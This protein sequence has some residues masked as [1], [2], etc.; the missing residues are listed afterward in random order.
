MARL[1]LRAGPI[2]RLPTGRRIRRPI[3]RAFRLSAFGV[4]LGFA[5]A[6]PLPAALWAGLLDAAAGTDGA[7]M[8]LGALVGLLS[9]GTVARR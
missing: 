7:L 2:L 1:L 9:L 4:G 8:L 3:G 5:L 6:L